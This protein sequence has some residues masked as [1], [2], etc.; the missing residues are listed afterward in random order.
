MLNALKS[1]WWVVFWLTQIVIHIIV[2]VSNFFLL[3]LVVAA[4]SYK[5]VQKVGSYH[6]GYLQVKFVILVVSFVLMISRLPS[7]SW[8]PRSKGRPCYNSPWGRRYGIHTHGTRSSS[9]LAMSRQDTFCEHV[10]QIWCVIFIFEQ[11]RTKQVIRQSGFDWSW[12]VIGIIVLISVL[13]MVYY[14]YNLLAILVLICMSFMYLPS[15][16][17]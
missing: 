13:V 16:P 2:Q 17:Q 3:L 11:L 10:G 8:I 1:V 15:V 9:D 12:D 7:C 5:S 4:L 6:D 14:T